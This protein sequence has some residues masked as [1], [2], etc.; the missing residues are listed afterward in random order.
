MNIISVFNEKK[1]SPRHR[2]ENK[3]ENRNGHKNGHRDGN[4]GEHKVI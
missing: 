2:D 3:D 4:R 1:P